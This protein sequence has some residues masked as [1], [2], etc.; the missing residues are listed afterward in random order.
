MPELL[1]PARA[2]AAS[3]LTNVIAADKFWHVVQQHD[4]V[5]AQTAISK[6]LADLVMGDGAGRDQVRALL[7]LDQQAQRLSATLLVNFAILDVQRRPLEMRWWQSALELSQSFA[8][9]F[10]RFLRHMRN[11]PNRRVWR[12]YAPMV[13]LRL[14]QHRQIVFLLRPLLNAP[15]NPDDWSQLH[16]AYR[17]AHDQGL[18]H[19]PVVITRFQDESGEQSTLEREYI[20]VLL[21][22]LMNRGRFSPYDAFWLSRWIPRWSRAL[23]LQSGRDDAGRSPAEDC[24]VV[25]LDRAEGLGR[26]S[27]AAAGS[28]LH[29]DPSPMLALIDAA[30]G[31]LDDPASGVSVPASFGRARQVRLLRKMTGNYTPRPPRVK[32]RGERQ[33]LASTTIAIVGPGRIMSMLRHEARK[34]T[35]AGRVAPPAVEAIT[36]ISE[37]GTTRSPAGAAGSPHGSAP[38]FEFGVPHQLWQ[39]KDGSTSGCRLR[40]PIGDARRVHPGTLVAIRDER[41]EGWSLVVVRRVGARIGDRVDFGVE[42]VG[43]NPRGVTMAID[44]GRPASASGSRQ[45]R[46]GLFS[47]LYLRESEQQPAM[48][49]K[50][51]II[52]PGAA[53][54]TRSLTLRSA[55]VEYVLRLKAPIE[56]QDDFVWLPYEIVDRRAIDGPPLAQATDGKTSLGPADKPQR[57]ATG[58]TAPS[59]WLLPPHP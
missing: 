18:L 1:T 21:L 41:G 40:A 10:V 42:Y 26:G 43:Q 31:A 29:L 48:P 6:A 13:L 25:D 32:R 15:P 57:P 46:R 22:E 23:S 39:V 58:F 34:R 35:A 2:D 49:L 59:D 47:A 14:F 52:A 16:A 28:T 7:H 37:G 56:E 36:I 8:L 53:G 30:T 45:G 51:L 19:Q 3:A 20:H 44:A 33:P 11:E 17:F 55:T 27:A 12:R 9:A 38:A 54:S 50:T 5:A 4:P 24:F